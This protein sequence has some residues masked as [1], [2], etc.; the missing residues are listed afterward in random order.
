MV[1]RSKW[2]EREM[3]ING[4]GKGSEKRKICMKKSVYSRERNWWEDLGDGEGRM[5]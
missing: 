1:E 4:W 3:V 2:V 5:G